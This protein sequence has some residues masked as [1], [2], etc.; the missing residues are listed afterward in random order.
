MSDQD[1]DP[2]K[3]SK[4]RSKYKYHIDSYNAL[5]QLKT[6]KEE[7]LNEIYKMIKTEMIESN[8]YPPQNAIN[9]IFDIII[10]NNR[11]TKS[12]LKLVKLIF[13]DSHIKEFRVSD[14][15]SG[16]MFYKEY[17]IKLDKSDDF[18]EFKPTNLDIHTENTIYKAIMYNNLKADYIH[19]RVKHIHCLNYVVTM[20]QLIVLNY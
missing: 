19:G 13:D 17:G 12:Y 11:Y 4:L 6:D 2:N 8:K 20:E 7:E 9:D 16:I 14:I 18:E 1:I 10:Y 3:Y 15:I 5:Y